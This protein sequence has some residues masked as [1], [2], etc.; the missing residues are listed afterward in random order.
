RSSRSVSIGHVPSLVF[1]MNVRVI[2]ERGSCV[3]R[4]ETAAS[5]P[6][7]CTASPERW[8]QK[9][10]PLRNDSLGTSLRARTISVTQSL[11]TIWP[12]KNAPHNER[13]SAAVE[14]TPPSPL[15]RTGRCSRLV[16]EPSAVRYP[17][18]ARPGSSS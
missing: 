8:S 6:C 17:S 1:E 10:R 3:L 14:E 15:P 7:H 16:L 13:T 4:N 11:D 9:P 2:L 18:A 5:Y 12:A